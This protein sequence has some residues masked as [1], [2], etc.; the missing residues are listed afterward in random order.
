MRIA[1]SGLQ[2]RS[3]H[4]GNA[5][6][7]GSQSWKPRH[8]CDD[9]NRRDL[10]ILDGNSPVEQCV[11]AL[12]RPAWA[13]LLQQLSGRQLTCVGCV[14]A[15][16]KHAWLSQS[17][18]DHSCLLSAAIRIGPHLRHC[19]SVHARHRTPLQASPVSLSSGSPEVQSMGPKAKAG[20]SCKRGA[21]G[22][23]D[24][25]CTVQ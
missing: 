15:C 3:R 9:C 16:E 14:G 6:Q 1:A 19:V 8:S 4:A 10:G 11:I 12:E 24:V 21:A 25:R 2:R 13:G 18:D 7:C 5:N 20:A 23:V 22:S 17:R